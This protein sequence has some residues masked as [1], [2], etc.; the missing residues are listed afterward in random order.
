MDTAESSEQRRERLKALA[1]ARVERLVRGQDV[2]PHVDRPEN[3]LLTQEEADRGLV[4]LLENGIIEFPIRDKAVRV[5][6]I[7]EERAP[8]KHR[9]ICSVSVDGEVLGEPLLCDLKDLETGCAF[10]VPEALLYKFSNKYVW[11]RN[12]YNAL[13]KVIGDRSFTGFL[14]ELRA[15]RSEQDEQRERLLQRIVEEAERFRDVLVRKYRQLTYMDEYETRETAKFL[16]EAKRFAGKRLPDLPAAAV[17]EVIVR[18][19]SEWADEAGQDGS[20]IA[21]DASM[22]PQDYERFCADRFAEAGWTARLTKAS[23]DQGADIV[24]EADGRRLVVQ[25]KLYSSSV[26][27]GA[28]Q[29]VIAAREFE[30]ADLAAVVSNAP[31]TP[32]AKELASATSVQLLHHDEIPTLKPK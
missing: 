26:G 10:K 30:Y 13:F 15:H 1:K 4:G 22:S 17:A 11:G 14:E 7:K 8:G 18:L 24:C 27:N 9:L 29:E 2:S 31:F 16:E 25:C 21:F 23:G 32:A 5:V 3:R 6:R 19:V 20:D 12:P 28:V